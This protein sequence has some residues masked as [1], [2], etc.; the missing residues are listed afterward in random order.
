MKKILFRLSLICIFSISNSVFAQSLSKIKPPTVSTS[1]ASLA[2]MQALFETPDTQ[3]LVK[4]QLIENTDLRDKSIDFLKNNPDTAVEMASVFKKNSGIKSKIMEYVLK[5]PELTKKVMDYIDPNGILEVPDPY[6]DGRFNEVYDLLDE[7]V[8][9]C[10][11]D[12]LISQ[13]N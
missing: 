6:Y 8:A 11:S 3:K 4:E 13:P 12:I 10:M 9:K 2:Q 5:T 7:A 1:D